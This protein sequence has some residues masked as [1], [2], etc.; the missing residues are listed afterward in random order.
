MA[1]ET[2]AE[3]AKKIREGLK[4]KF[5]GQKFSVRS[6]SFSLG[7]AVRIEWM[8]GPTEAQVSRIAQPHEAVTRDT[9]TGEILGGGNRYITMRREYS[10]G[11]LRRVAE[12]VCRERDLPMPTIKTTTDGSHAYITDADTRYGDDWLQHIIYRAAGETAGPKAE[13]AQKAAAPA[14]AEM[15]APA[16]R[17]TITN[18]GEP[19]TSRQLFLLHCLLRRDTRGWTLTK[20]EASDLIDAI[21]NGQ[22]VADRLPA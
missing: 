8:D 15:P 1:Y 20:Q 22:D 9:M 21:K 3:T 19:A 14:K 6:D 2:V 17:P 16:E 4:A 7:S 10:E 13:P 12:R 5:P 18:P 11:L